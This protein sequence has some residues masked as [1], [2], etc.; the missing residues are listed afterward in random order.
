MHHS[1]ESAPEMDE[2]IRRNLKLGATGKFPEGKLNKTDEG[3]IAFAIRVEH[4]KIV[5]DFGTSVTWLGMDA[6]QATGLA[7]LL[8][9]KT[10]QIRRNRL[11]SAAKPKE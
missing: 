7:K 4:N 1:S 6:A 11:A 3:E 9:E 2:E 5:I 10:A 8:L